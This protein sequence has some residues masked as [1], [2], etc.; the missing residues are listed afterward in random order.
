MKSARQMVSEMTEHLE[1]N[2]KAA[3]FAISVVINS[4][5]EVE[6]MTWEKPV[7]EISFD[8]EN[9]EL[10]LFV[11]FTEADDMLPISGNSFL[12]QY[13]VELEK[14]SSYS[15]CVSDKKIIDDLTVRVD[16][17]LIG[18]GESE[19]NMKFFAVVSNGQV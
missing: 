9:K 17:P 15:V 13:A 2:S 4:N 7:G 11:P 1:S 18:F 10:I 8:H 19:D 12:S 3:L 14:Y 6:S 5:N 16:R